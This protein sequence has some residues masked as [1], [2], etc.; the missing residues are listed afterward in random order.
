MHIFLNSKG[1]FIQLLVKVT[2]SIFIIRSLPHLLVTSKYPGL[3]AFLI[4]PLAVI[5]NICQ[6]GQVLWFFLRQLYFVNLL[7]EKVVTLN[8]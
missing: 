7:I 6:T 8:L 5:R 4:R 3:P 2:Y 1:F